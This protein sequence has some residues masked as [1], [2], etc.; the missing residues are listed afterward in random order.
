MKWMFGFSTSHIPLFVNSPG[1]EVLI[2]K[3]MLFRI[4]VFALLKSPD[5]QQNSVWRRSYRVRNIYM[6]CS[7]TKDQTF[8][9]VENWFPGVLWIVFSTLCTVLLVPQALLISTAP[10]ILYSTTSFFK[11]LYH[12]Y[13]IS[14]VRHE[15][16]AW[17]F[18]LAC[19]TLPR[20]KHIHCKH[21]L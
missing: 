15:H 8:E 4:P 11:F 10:P 18:L 5:E 14:K 3:L 2:N 21:P 13:H 6:C 17:L 19:T 7:N 16:S 20:V 9:T 12:N 1:K